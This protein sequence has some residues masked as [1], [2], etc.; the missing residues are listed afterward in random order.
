MEKKELTSVQIARR[1]YEEKN[2]E[3]RKA[4]SAQFST[5]IPRKFND[6]LKEFLK[7]HKISKVCLIYAWFDALTKEYEK[8][9]QEKK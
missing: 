8:P 3:E 1:K 5:F 2:K 9:E 6:E 4:A 7:K